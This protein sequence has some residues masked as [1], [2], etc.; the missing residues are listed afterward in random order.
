MC[1]LYSYVLKSNKCNSLLFITFLKSPDL[2]THPVYAAGP[3]R[4]SLSKGPSP[5]GLAVVNR[6]TA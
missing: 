6:V 3:C 2:L 4:R 1:T 5:L